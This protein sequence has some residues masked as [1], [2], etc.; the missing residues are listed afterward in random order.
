MNLSLNF[1]TTYD[2]NIKDQPRAFA[3]GKNIIDF[4]KNQMNVDVDKWIALQA[5]HGVVHKANIGEKYTWFGIGY[6]SNMYFKFIANHPTYTLIKGGDLVFTSCINGGKSGTA[7]P[8]QSV[9]YGD[10]DGNPVP[11]TAW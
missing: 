4:G 11:N 3:D 6:L 8:V 9:A 2:S 10:V 5:I 1:S 7:I